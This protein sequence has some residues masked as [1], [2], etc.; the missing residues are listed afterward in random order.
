[1]E[2]PRNIYTLLFM[3]SCL[4]KLFWIQSPNAIDWLLFTSSKL[5]KNGSNLV[6]T[7]LFEEESQG[8]SKEDAQLYIALNMVDNNYLSKD[9]TD[10]YL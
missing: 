3:L 6:S 1:M 5:R 7:S 10:N 8:V 4:G 9:C 2:L